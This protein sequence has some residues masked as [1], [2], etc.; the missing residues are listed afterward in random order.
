MTITRRDV[1]FLLPGLF[2]AGAAIDAFAG[3]GNSLPSAD[4]P[5]EKHPVQRLDHA[6]MRRVLCPI[7]A[8]P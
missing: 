7:A 6:E 8:N 5:F 4:Y 1:C 2:S 3:E